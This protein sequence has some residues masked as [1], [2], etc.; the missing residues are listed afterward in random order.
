MGSATRP[1][2]AGSASPST[3]SNS[4]SS[5]CFA[6]LE[7]SPA[8]TPCA[9]GC[10]NDCLKSEPELNSG[11][12]GGSR[13]AAATNKMRGLMAGLVERAATYMAAPAPALL[14]V[15]AATAILSAGSTRR[16]SQLPSNDEKPSFDDT[17]KPVHHA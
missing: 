14:A 9:R 1:R 4:T 2:R 6:S 5:R 17:G 16:S 15:R 3:P 7:P 11:Q 8:P 10:G 12:E 13:S